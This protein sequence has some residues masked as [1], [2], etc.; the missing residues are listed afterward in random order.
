MP[1]LKNACQIVRHYG[2][3]ICWVIVDDV[4]GT[5]RHNIRLLWQLCDV[6]YDVKDNSLA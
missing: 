5:D 2:A 3:G 1:K 6:Q 4:L